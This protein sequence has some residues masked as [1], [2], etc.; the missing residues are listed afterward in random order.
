MNYLAHAW[1]SFNHSEI[2]VGNMISDFIKGKK[3]FDFSEGIQK[4]IALHRAIDTFTDE[5]NVTRQ[6]KQFFKPVVGLYAGAFIDVVYDHFLAR[7]KN[8]FTDESLEQ[9]SLFVYATLDNYQNVLPDR[10]LLMFPYMK[11]DNWLYNYRTLC[12]AEKSFGGLIRRAKYLEDNT[13]IFECFEENYNVLQD[14][15]NNFFPDVK[16]FTHETIA[17]LNISQ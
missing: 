9:F 17:T 7:D 3:R 6:A 15:Y 10:F 5:H 8:E 13:A 4:G 2:L 14:C 12:G 11:R 1:L 16:N